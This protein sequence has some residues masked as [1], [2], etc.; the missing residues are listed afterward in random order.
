[1]LTIRILGPIKADIDGTDVVLSRL[2]Q[3]AVLGLLVTARGQVISTDRMVDE[4]WTTRPPRQPLVSLQAYVSNLRRALEPHRASH[5]RA[6]VLVRESSGYAL[7]LP[8]DAVD[9]WRF[10]RALAGVT[11]LPAASTCS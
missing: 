4:L 7:K 2:R 11:A 10:E 1:M 6:S 9:A 5:G 3:R 8:D